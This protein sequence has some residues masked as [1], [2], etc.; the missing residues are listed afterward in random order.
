MDLKDESEGPDTS[1][2]I[3]QENKIPRMSNTE[4][5][6]KNERNKFLVPI[7][8][9]IY[10]RFCSVLKYVTICAHHGLSRMSMMCLTSTFAWDI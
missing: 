7:P 5:E 2:T 8:S 4:K 3:L 10:I 1:K 6:K 9:F